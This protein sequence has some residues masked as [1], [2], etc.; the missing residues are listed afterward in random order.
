MQERNREGWD[1]NIRLKGIEL[2]EKNYFLR[3]RQKL[4]R[5][6]NFF[7]ICLS[8]FRRNKRKIIKW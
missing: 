8:S 2:M 7:F 1:G 6:V 5:K 4:D 3:T